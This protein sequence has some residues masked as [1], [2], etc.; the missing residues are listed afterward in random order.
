M[1]SLEFELPSV[2]TGA[3][4]FLKILLTEAILSHKVKPTKW[5]VALLGDE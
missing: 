4:S 3:T 2:F 5:Q 1:F